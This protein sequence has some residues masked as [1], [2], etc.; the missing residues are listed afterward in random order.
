MNI[1]YVGDF[2]MDLYRF[3]TAAVK[4]SEDIDMQDDVEYLQLTLV[5]MKV[6]Y[7]T[8]KLSDGSVLFKVK[9]KYN[10]ILKDVANP[11]LDLMENDWTECRTDRKQ[12]I[13]DILN[14]LKCTIEMEDVGDNTTVIRIF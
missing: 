12:Y 9:G 4:P 14:D 7:K 1:Q 11:L 13:G 10:T 5:R 3:S 8:E 2:L 6:I